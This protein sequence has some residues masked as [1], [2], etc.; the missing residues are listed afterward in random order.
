LKACISVFSKFIQSLGVRELNEIY[1][2][3]AKEIDTPAAKIVSFSINSYYGK[4]DM[5]ELETLAKEFESN[6]VAMQILKARVKAYVYN[7]YIDYKNKQRI[8]AYL[9]MKVSPEDGKIAKGF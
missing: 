6:P 1:K 5:K 9:Q 7:N 2:E 4:I 8:A 3:V